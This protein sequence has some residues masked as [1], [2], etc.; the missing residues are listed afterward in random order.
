MDSEALT[1][2]ASR[3]DLVA[4]LVLALFTGSRGAWVWGWVYAQM[5]RDRDDWKAM[6]LSGTIIADR[7]VST[8]EK[9]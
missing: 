4:V 9:K 1:V 2:L 3:L 7:T 5:V 8:L 6:A